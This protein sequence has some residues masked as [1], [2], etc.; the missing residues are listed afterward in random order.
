MWLLPFAPCGSER[1]TRLSDWS[2][3][4]WKSL[5][6]L[7]NVLGERRNRLLTLV[8]DGV[9]HLIDPARNPLH[10]S[11]PHAAGCDSRGSDPNPG[12]VERLTRI[13]WDSV[14][15]GRDSSAIKR[16]CGGLSRYAL[17]GQ[18]DQDQM[19]VGSTRD[20][21]EAAFEQAAGQRLRI[22]NRLVRVVG[23]L[24]L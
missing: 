22:Q 9:N 12:G 11:R 7:P 17:V 24:G 18:I 10:L 21:L 23:K 6:Q 5:S 15:V 19:V 4:D 3:R 13:E 20:Q 1:S 8:S 2:T 14:V 16:L